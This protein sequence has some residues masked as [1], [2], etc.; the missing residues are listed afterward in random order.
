MHYL[1]Y[2]EDEESVEMIMKKFETL[3]R[4]KSTQ[5]AK[6]EVEEE[7]EP[8][9]CTETP[10]AEGEVLTEDQMIELFKETSNFTVRGA[11]SGKLLSIS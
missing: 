4:I 1:G 5:A 9:P 2:V 8:G 6:P 3:E 10:V 7:A 11:M